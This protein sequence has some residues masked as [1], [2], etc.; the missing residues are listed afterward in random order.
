VTR[1][2]KDLGKWRLAF[3]DEDRA[4]VQARLTVL[5]RDMGAGGDDDDVG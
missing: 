4:A 5:D 2:P 1:K 3:E